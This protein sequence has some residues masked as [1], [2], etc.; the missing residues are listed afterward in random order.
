MWTEGECGMNDMVENKMQTPIEWSG[1]VVIT[2]AQL[3]EV[4]GTTADNINSNFLKNKDRFNEGKHYITLVGEELRTF[5]SN[6]TFGG[7]VGKTAKQLYLWTRRGASRHCK[8][9]GTDKAWEQFDYLED[10]YFERKT[11]PKLPKTPMELLELHYEAIKQVDHKVDTLEDRFNKL[12][13]DMPVF[14]IDA[15]NIQSAV[16]RKGVDVLG[17]KESNAYKDKST[18]TSVY[19]DIQCMLRRN[20]GVRR[21]EE[22][23]HSQADVAI[24]LVE[25]YV[26]PLILQ[27]KVDMENAQM[28]FA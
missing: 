14:T 18:R 3:A 9:L 13:A 5:K 28:R 22:I 6:P 20:F 19:A 21:Y 27:Q 24:R 7:V 11:Q 12:E 1:Q 16:K 4:Y 17:G 8:I 2:T 25:E 26:P 15:K 10:N 23:K